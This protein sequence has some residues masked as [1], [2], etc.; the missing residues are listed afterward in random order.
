MESVITVGVRG[1]AFLKIVVSQHFCCTCIVLLLHA[2]T[3]ISYRFI[4]PTG[5]GEDFLTLHSSPCKE[6]TIISVKQHD[7]DIKKRLSSLK[8]VFLNVI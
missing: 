3:Q 2:E 6:T 8:C 4:A 1:E 7:L 5:L